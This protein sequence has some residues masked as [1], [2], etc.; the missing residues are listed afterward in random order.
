MFVVLEICICCTN[1]HN[2][3]NNIVFLQDKFFS[4]FKF[5]SCLFLQKVIKRR[6]VSWSAC[7]STTIFQTAHVARGVCMC[8]CV[9][10]CVGA[11]EFNL[12]RWSWRHDC[13]SAV[14]AYSKDYCVRHP[15]DS[16]RG[17]FSRQST[18]RHLAD[19]KDVHH[20]SSH[21]RVTYLT[22]GD[23]AEAACHAAV[24][25]ADEEAATPHSVGGPQTNRFL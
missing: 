9:C 11:G 22:N 8:V 3:N 2:D 5:C 25:A 4:C 16:S 6:T 7:L 14:C 1:K 18:P 12:L 19:V 23:V 17:T 10:A 24:T 15:V 21:Y 13:R 20:G